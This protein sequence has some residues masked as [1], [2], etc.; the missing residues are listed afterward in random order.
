M[1]GNRVSERL[2]WAVTTLDVQPADRLLEIGCGHGVAVSLVCERLVSGHLL[3]IDRSSAMVAAARRRNAAHEAA[4]KVSFQVAAL[5]QADLGD[6]QF[7]TIFAFRIGV[8]VR[9]SPERELAI[10]SKHLAP[11][12]RFHLVYD[13]ASGGEALTIVERGVATLSRHSFIVQ[14]ARIETVVQT[15]I[16]AIIAGKR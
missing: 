14:S 15:T 12:G 7:D 10:I 16:V 8:F 1:S 5:D 13:P 9:G 6:A 4:G 11:G 2:A 3:A